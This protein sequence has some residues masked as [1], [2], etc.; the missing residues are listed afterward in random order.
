MHALAVSH[1][2][3]TLRLMS[4]N[5]R[6]FASIGAVQV[7][8]ILQQICYSPDEELKHDVTFW[9]IAAI[10]FG[11]PVFGTVTSACLI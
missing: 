5:S 4:N 3:F 9:M 11:L 6:L 8:F 1:L 7:R 2:T 10:F